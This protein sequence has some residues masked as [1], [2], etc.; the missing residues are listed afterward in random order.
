MFDN[1][2]EPVVH[3]TKPPNQY[4][5]MKVLIGQERPTLCSDV[6]S[7]A[8]VVLQWVTERPPWDLQVLPTGFLIIP[9]IA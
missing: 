7:L 3:P 9:C 2:D 8:A 5:N 4:D 1:D 6:W